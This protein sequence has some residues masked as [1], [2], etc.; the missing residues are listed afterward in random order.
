MG[1]KRLNK[2]RLIYLFISASV[3]TITS[4]GTSS[5]NTAKQDCLIINNALSGVNT[6]QDFIANQKKYTAKFQDI[7]MILEDPKLSGA[8]KT[9]AEINWDDFDMSKMTEIESNV[10]AMISYCAK[11]GV[12]LD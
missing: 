7:W 9:L 5:T 4:C 10:Y 2:I 12:N 1:L 11:N 3:I 6:S 8:V